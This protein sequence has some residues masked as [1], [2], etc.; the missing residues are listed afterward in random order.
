MEEFHSLPHSPA[1]MNALVNIYG[2]A[3]LMHP[4]HICRYG[5]ESVLGSMHAVP[6]IFFLVVCL[7]LS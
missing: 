6:L 7:H 3:V 2:E 1:L 4:R 5:R